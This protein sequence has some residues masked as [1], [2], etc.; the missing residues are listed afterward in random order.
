MNTTNKNFLTSYVNTMLLNRPYSD[1]MAQAMSR[2]SKGNYNNL[3]CSK[4]PWIAYQF[5]MQWDIDSDGGNIVKSIDILNSHYGYDYAIF[6][7]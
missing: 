6:Q 4:G 1:M 2:L 7:Q 5:A 3:Y